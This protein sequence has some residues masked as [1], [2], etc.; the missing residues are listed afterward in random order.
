MSPYAILGS[1]VGTAEA[2]SLCRRLTAWHD[3]IVAHERR[4]RSGRAS[5]ASDDECP[6]VEARTLWADAVAT[7]GPR[8]GEPT[9]L[10]SR[11][12]GSARSQEDMQL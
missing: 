1:S 5:D 3:A 7:L 2:A 4:L 9:F 6:H 11:A 10:R 8:A 12:S